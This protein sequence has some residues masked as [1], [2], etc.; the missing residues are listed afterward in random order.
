M[1]ASSGLI[2]QKLDV[3]V[4][5]DTQGWFH[6]LRGERERGMEWRDLVREGLGWG[7]AFG[8]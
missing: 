1:A 2:S 5:G 6:P 4:W 7:T 8:K 3:L